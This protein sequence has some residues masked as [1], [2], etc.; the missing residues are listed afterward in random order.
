MD[1]SCL[2]VVRL[3]AYLQLECQPLSWNTLRPKRPIDLPFDGRGHLTRAFNTT[4]AGHRTTP[5]RN[6]RALLFLLPCADA[7]AA[8][9]GSLCEP[10]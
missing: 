2:L 9:P 3:S 4:I 10:F 7:T 5:S 1:G 6:E 8:G